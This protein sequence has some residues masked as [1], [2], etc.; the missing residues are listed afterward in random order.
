MKRRVL[1]TSGIQVSALGVGCMGLSEFYGPMADCERRA[2]IGRALD[3]GV[4]F[5][6][7]ADMYGNGANEELLGRELAP[8]R[9]SIVL[10]TKCGIIRDRSGKRVNGTPGYVRSACEASLRRLRTDHVDLLYLHRVDPA[11]PIEESVGAMADLV[12]DGKAR[13]IGLSKLDAATLA[14]ADAVYP[15]AAVQAQYS[16]VARR[17]EA[18]LIGVC[19]LRGIALV[20]Y[21]PLCKGLLAG[22]IVDVSHLDA[23]DWRRRDQRFQGTALERNL[24]VIDAIRRHAQALGCT[25]A[26]LALAW[27][28]SRGPEVVPIPGMRSPA[29][30]EDNAGAAQVVVPPHTLDALET[31]Y[32]EDSGDAVTSS[33][34]PADPQT[35]TA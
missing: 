19:R 14:R 13:A 7:T 4:T 1:G 24:P 17:V 29:Q 8:M 23:D 15:I 5:F 35:V 31:L 32:A 16:L 10:A 33:E 18:E 3:A 9:A 34:R 25:A 20:A 28:L 6:D 12:R 2:T 11:T 22:G 21:S 26:Q 27:L 30:V